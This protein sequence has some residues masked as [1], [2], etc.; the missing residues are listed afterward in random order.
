MPA[1]NLH[2]LQDQYMSQHN[3]GVRVCVSE[4]ILIREHHTGACAIHYSIVYATSRAPFLEM[5]DHHSNRSG[6]LMSDRFMI[7]Q[8]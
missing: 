4:I 7:Q 2:V 5:V 6:G 8:D 3:Q 1:E